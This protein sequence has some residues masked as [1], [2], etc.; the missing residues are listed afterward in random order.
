MLPP[1]NLA[2][3]IPDRPDTRDLRY[4]APSRHEAATF[5][6]AASLRHKC[7][8]VEDQGY[9]GS[10]TAQA[11]TSAMEFLYVHEKR[12]APQLSR[13]FCYY[14]TRVWV[15]KEAPENDGGARIRDTMKALATYGS[16]LERL[17][18]HDLEAYKT[19]PPP[20]AIRDAEKHQ[21][22]KYMRV[23]GLDAIKKSILAGFPVV[24]G[25]SIPSTI[26]DAYTAETGVIL[27]PAKWTVLRGGHAVLVVG[28]DDHKKQLCFKNSW[29]SGWGNRGFGYLPYAYVTDGL[30][31]DFWTIRS[32]EL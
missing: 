27:M 15:A 9:L 5:I 26:Y 21:I 7:T 29:G 24:I 1:R 17:W 6:P 19:A 16:C 23:D 28:Y 12:P 20:A 30:A 25:F 13:L 8:H 18:P 4:A 32:E 3:W 14:A 10:C 31:G 2:G 22:T 11:A